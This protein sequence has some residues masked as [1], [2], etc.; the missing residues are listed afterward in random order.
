MRTLRA[1]TVSLLWVILVASLYGCS[2]VEDET[3]PNGQA[4]AGSASSSQE[5][6]SEQVESQAPTESVRLTDVLALWESGK[7]DD[8]AKQLALIHWDASDVFSDL[9]VLNLSEDRFMSFSRSERTSMQE[10]SLQLTRTLR[11]IS[12]HVLAAGDN[13]QASGD[14][15]AAKASYQAVQHFGE[16]L[17]NPERLQVIQMIG[18]GIANSA[19]EKATAME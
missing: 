2:R 14:N 6:P 3:T 5:A 16:A 19:Q 12:R 1:S 18:K 11:A 10:E 17:S 9:P 8:A 15:E 7:K 4:S 13:W